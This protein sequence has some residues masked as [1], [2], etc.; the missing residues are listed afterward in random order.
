M[1]RYFFLW[2][3]NVKKKTRIRGSNSLFYFYLGQP[4]LMQWVYKND[5]VFIVKIIPVHCHLLDF[6]S[7]DPCN[8]V[9]FSQS[10]RGFDF[11]SF[12]CPEN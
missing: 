7:Y 11:L 1:N 2:I 3:L 12:E 8:D 5:P 10:T 9:I 6:D 4:F